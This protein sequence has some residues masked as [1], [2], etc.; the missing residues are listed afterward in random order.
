MV[1]SVL[2]A[3]LTVTRALPSPQ[4]SF[5]DFPFGP[6]H[7]IEVIYF[8]DNDPAGSTIVALPVEGQALGNPVKTSTGGVGG[9]GENA[10]GLPMSPDGLFSQG[11]IIVGDDVRHACSEELTKL[12]T[13]T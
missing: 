3:I 13:S 12:L 7:T 4:V 2:F 10:Q 5:S 1:L 8:L 9:V 6:G 11:S